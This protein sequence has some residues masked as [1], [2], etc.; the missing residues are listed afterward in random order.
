MSNQSKPSHSGGQ[1]ELREALQQTKSAFRIILLFSLVINLLMLV[2]PIYMLQVYQRV[3]GSGHVE[4]LLFLTLMAAGAILVMSVLDTLRTSLTIR[5]GCWL[6]NRLGPVYL[7]TGVRGRLAG[8][9]TG[10]QSLRDISQIQS[11]I[12]TQGL[13]AFFDSPW[14]PIFILIIW[15]LHP[16]LGVVALVSALLLLGLSIANDLVTRKPTVEANKFQMQAMHLAEATVRNAEVVRAMGLLPAMVERW[17]GVNSVSVEALRAAGEAG[18]I[19]MA[20]TK[21]V[22]F[23]VQIAI[24]GTGAWLVIQQQLTPGG[25]IAASIMLGRALAPVE[26]AIG[27]WKNFMAAKIAYGRLVDQIENH[28]ADAPRTILPEP[29]G[30][31]EINGLS[32]AIPGTGQL[33][34]SNINFNVEPGEAIAVIGPS[35]AGKSTL[36]RLLVGLAPPAV[37]EVRLDGSDVRHWDP[38]QLGQY[39]GYLPQDVELFGGTVRENI[40]RMGEAT[41]EQVIRAAQLAQAHQMIQRLPA[42]YDTETGD[43]GV[44]LSGGQRQRIGLARAVFGTPKLLVLDEPNAN[45]DQVGESALAEAISN[46]KAQGCALIIV[47]HRPSTL[48]EADKVLVIKDGVQAMFGPRD[49]ILQRLTEL[50]APPPDAAPPA[51]PEKDR[52]A[53][54]QQNGHFAGHQ[55]HANGAAS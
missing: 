17:R 32:Y 44:R 42:G 18:G 12:S 1:N 54:A 41:D 4:T 51:A 23:F 26:M 28:P 29:E 53:A 25:M 11:F 34:L 22:R 48:A 6:N 13:T 5:I 45:L 35:G 31:L 19:I 37:G 16:L 46:L 47:G 36:C 9:P 2:A 40:A 3:L 10:A 52:P 38:C 14:V 39:I 24:L 30:R 50:S 33:L 15:M 27:A 49:E 21:F 55:P 43:S 8:D 20:L 7:D